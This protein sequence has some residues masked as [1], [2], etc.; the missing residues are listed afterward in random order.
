[1]NGGI[2]QARLR[3]MHS[4]RSYL[5]LKIPHYWEHNLKYIITQKLYLL[6]AKTKSSRL[7]SL[8]RCKKLPTFLIFNLSPATV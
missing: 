3:Q 5:L 8:H 2:F 6:P 4:L 7:L 1:M